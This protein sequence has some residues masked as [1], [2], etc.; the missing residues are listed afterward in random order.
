MFVCLHFF[1]QTNSI[2]I[3]SKALHGYLCET[4]TTYVQSA[5]NTHTNTHKKQILDHKVL[6]PGV[7][8]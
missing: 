8:W 4:K 5:K 3:F 2:N 7:E 6:Y 1:I